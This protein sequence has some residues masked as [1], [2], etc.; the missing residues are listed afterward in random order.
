MF[1][2]STNHQL[3]RYYSKEAS[4][5]SSAEVDAF[6]YGWQ[7]ELSPHFNPPWTLIPAVLQ[8]LQADKVRGIMVVPEWP[9]AD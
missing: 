5:V 6:H 2:S 3:P 1:A 7:L 4:D 9:T 8:N